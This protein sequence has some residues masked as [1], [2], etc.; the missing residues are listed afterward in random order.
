M[1]PYFTSPVAGSPKAR[2]RPAGTVPAGAL[3]PSPH[4]L[5]AVNHDLLAGNEAGFFG[6]HH[7]HGVADVLRTSNPPQRHGLLP[8]PQHIRIVETEAM[9][10]LVG[11]TLTFSGD[12]VVRLGSR[13]RIA[14]KGES[15]D[16]FVSAS[17]EELDTG[18]FR[19][20]AES[21]LGRALLGRRVGDRVRFRAPGGVMGVTVRGVR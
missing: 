7:N 13:V 16:E 15:E 3:G 21:P 12:G 4:V 6:K 14:Y 8:R 18:A 1:K 19:L 20:S 10:R 17:A 2:L 11:E 5:A 9:R